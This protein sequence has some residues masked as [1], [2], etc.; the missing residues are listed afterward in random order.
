M[1]TKKRKERTGRLPKYCRHAAT[2][3]AYV[4]LNGQRLYLGKQDTPESREAYD[5]AIAEWLANGRRRPIAA[6][7]LHIAELADR[8][9]DHAEVYYRD[10]DGQPGTEFTHTKLALRPLLRLYSR[11]TAQ[12][13]GPRQ[14]KTLQNEW[15]ESDLSR[16]MVNRYVSLIK[17]MFKWG[18]S[19]CLVEAQVFGALTA[20]SG[21]RKGRS[22]AKEPREVLPVPADDIETVKPF[23][24]SPVWAMIQLQRLTA[25][26]PG[27]LVAL[28]PA[29]IDTT[30][31]VWTVRLDRHKTRHHGRERVLYF[32][33]KAQAVLRPFML[34]L[35]D[36]PLFSPQESVR[37]LKARKASGS[38]RNGQ[39]MTPRKTDRVVGDQFTPA[40][41]RRA[42]TRACKKAKIDAWYPYQLRHTAATEIRQSHGIEAAQH[43]LG[44]ANIRVTEIY[45]EK[46]ASVAI[47]VAREVG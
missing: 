3:Q 35:A 39:P 37:E 34:R 11:L 7:D 41:Y 18:V 21:L 20:V 26:R 42:I 36:T 13:F 4:T 12:E 14:L 5:R 44:H 6:D 27:E 33:E 43:V 9:L 17:R 23:V 40:S 25:A 31:T 24:S 30:G 8:Y 22:A 15:V 38:R 46:A 16:S 10:P 28:R 47:K 19:E 2:G 29:D 1:P 45:A 32:G